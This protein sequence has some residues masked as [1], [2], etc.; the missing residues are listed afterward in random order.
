MYSDPATP[1]YIGV[2]EDAIELRAAIRREYGFDKPVFIQYLLYLKRVFTLNF[3]TS[4]VY[5]EPVIKVMF[6]RIP[7]SLVLTLSSMIISVIVGIIIGSNASKKR[8]KWQDKALLKAS[9][10]STAIPSFW[11]ALLGVMLFAFIIPIFPYKGAL[12]EGYTLH[13]NKILFLI[14]FI[15]TIIAS[16]IVY[17]LF[18]KQF[19][20]FLIPLI[21]FIISIIASTN[22]FD[23]LDIAYH[24]FL[25]VLVMTIG[26]ILSYALLVR[27]SMINVY[28]EDYIL[29]ARAKGLSPRMIKYKHAFKNSL[30]PL[31]TNIGLSLSGLFGG[32]LLIEKIFS[33]PGMG[34]LLV[35]ANNNGD[36]LLAQAIMIFFAII[37]IIANLITDFIY[38]KF[39]P[40]VRVDQ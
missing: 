38:H 23:F 22:F 30:L 5:K 39:D 7:W 14:L 11:I 37:T 25:P 33:W 15:L 28:K 10:I 16:I 36:F 9:T 6:K 3:G 34:S 18:K 2:P 27:N 17:K 29:L 8:G 13:F 20:I 35:E 26:S 19:L 24:A 31:I 1:Y 32:S 4:Y 40:R 21:G 12:T